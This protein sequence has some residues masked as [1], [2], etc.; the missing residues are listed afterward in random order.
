MNEFPLPDFDFDE[1]PLVAIEKSANISVTDFSPKEFKEICSQLGFKVDEKGPIRSTGN[2]TVFKVEKDDTTEKWAIKASKHKTR[3]IKEFKKR[4]KFEDSPFLVKSFECFHYKNY[5]LL[6]MELCP[7]GD[8]T[9][10]KFSENECWLLI[11]DICQALS[12]IHKKNCIHLDISPSNILKSGNAFKLA[13]FGTLIELGKYESGKE[14]AGPY[15]SPET[16]LYNGVDDVHV[17][18]KTDI[19][20]LGVVLLEAASGFMAPRGG[21]E[22]YGQ[23]RA[24]KLKFGG[25]LYRC[26]CSQELIDC[27]NL[28][29]SHDPTERPSAEDLKDHP[30]ALAAADMFHCI[31]NP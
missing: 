4:N 30:F 2:S 25:D 27:I 24:G 16:M 1:I 8:I 11:Y 17:G 20:S 6:L 29:I 3:L 19:F 22:R 21:D 10:K 18:T 9:G 23:L 12:I 7:E 13:D 15:C 26:D 28:M 14:G 5:S 31:N